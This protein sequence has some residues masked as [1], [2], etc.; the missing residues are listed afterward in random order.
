M[1]IENVLSKECLS[2]ER[3][4]GEFLSRECFSEGGDE[5]DE[6]E[7]PQR[8]APGKGWPLNKHSD[9]E[10]DSAK[11]NRGLHF[12]KVDNDILVHHGYVICFVILFLEMIYV[13]SH[14]IETRF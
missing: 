4:S 7:G 5:E 14:T 13:Y 12:P 1:A 9:C 8:R 6:E 10:F 3:L 11:K 2:G